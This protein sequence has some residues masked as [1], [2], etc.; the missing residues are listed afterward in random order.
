[1]PSR[2]LPV[3]EDAI[4]AQQRIADL[5]HDSGLLRQPLQVRRF[6]DDRFNLL[7]SG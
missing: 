1:M 3:S 6:W 4:A 5:F 2:L 7:L